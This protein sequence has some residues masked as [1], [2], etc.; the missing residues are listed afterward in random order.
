M[1]RKIKSYVVLGLFAVLLCDC[2]RSEITFVEKQAQ[3]KL[4]ASDWQVRKEGVH[5]LA[6]IQ[7]KIPPMSKKTGDVLLKAFQDEIKQ[8]KDFQ[9]KKRAEGKF[10]DQIDDAFDNQFPVNLYGD[11]VSSLAILLA[12]TQIKGSLPMIFQFL[13]ET[14]Y[15]TS[16]V[17]PTL[18]G[19]EGLQYLIEKE[20]VGQPEEKQVA[21]QILSLWANPPQEAEDWDP[22]MIPKLTQRQK[23][24]I[25]P[26][27]LKNLENEDSYTVYCATSAL[28]AFLE[29]SNVKEKLKEL[30][31]KG[32]DNDIRNEAKRILERMQQ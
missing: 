9:E 13:V 10:A 15:S 18:Y 24:Q 32:P 30:A 4:L 19:E 26:L 23:E 31:L 7:D 1:M 28:E 2:K 25:F 12:T 29:K 6:S 16:P 27:L 22:L 14:N 20:S 8:K 11:F 3:E 21:I 17:L 5:L